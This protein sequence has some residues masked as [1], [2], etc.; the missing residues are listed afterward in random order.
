MVFFLCHVMFLRFL[1]ACFFAYKAA[2]FFFNIKRESS[3]VEIVECSKKALFCGEC[4]DRNQTII[5]VVLVL[6]SL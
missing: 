5:L 2:R 3:S 1:E 6:V 4:C